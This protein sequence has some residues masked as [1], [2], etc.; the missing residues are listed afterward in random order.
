MRCIVVCQKVRLIDDARCEIIPTAE[1]L[2]LK[3]QDTSG[4]G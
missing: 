2:E 3:Y 4:G 1:G